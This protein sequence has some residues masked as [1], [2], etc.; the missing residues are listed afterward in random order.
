MNKLSKILLSG[1]AVTTCATGLLFVNPTNDKYSKNKTESKEQIAS[2]FG[3]GEK[4]KAEVGYEPK[5]NI[6]K[7]L[8]P[9]LEDYEISQKNLPKNMKYAGRRSAAYRRNL[10]RAYGCK[11]VRKEYNEKNVFGGIYL[12][13]IEQR[14]ESKHKEALNDATKNVFGRICAAVLEGNNH[15]ITIKTGLKN[16]NKHRESIKNIVKNLQSKY[17]L[18]PYHISPILKLDSQYKCIRRVFDSDKFN[19]F[20]LEGDESPQRR[21]TKRW[22]REVEKYH[23]IEVGRNGVKKIYSDNPFKK[24][25]RI[26]TKQGNTFHV[27]V[28]DSRYGPTYLAI[29]K[30][31]SASKNK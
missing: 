10:E 18:D 5:T 7:V 4:P 23:D 1:A 22:D 16:M 14:N 19:V 11:V 31:K 28:V 27:R 29:K 17:D 26:K 25:L 15:I 30:E 9:M 13:A 20:D 24:E 21:F 2:D 8:N 12:M 6:K 3:F